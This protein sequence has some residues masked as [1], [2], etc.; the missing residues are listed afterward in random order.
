MKKR[1]R[2]N[3]QNAYKSQKDNCTFLFALQS[4]T[5]IE[6]E[7][8]C[9]NYNCCQKCHCYHILYLLYSFVI[10]FVSNHKKSY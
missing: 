5:I 4:L 1:S 8:D 9:K 2:D 7:S 3:P 6:V 10:I